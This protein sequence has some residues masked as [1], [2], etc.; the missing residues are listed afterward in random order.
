MEI[1]K[2]NDPKANDPK[3]IEAGY[4]E[5]RD[6]ISRGTYRVKLR[7]ERPDGASFITARYAFAIKS[8]EVK[9]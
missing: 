3:I 1:I 2:P 4:V 8:D 9:E 7:T 5:M 6:L